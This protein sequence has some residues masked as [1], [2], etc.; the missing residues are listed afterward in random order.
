MKHYKKLFSFSELRLKGTSLLNVLSDAFQNFFRN[1]DWNQAAAIAFYGIVSL[2][3]LLIL[4]LWVGGLIFGSNP[5]LQADIISRIKNINPSFPDYLLRQISQIVHNKAILGWVGLITLLW[6]S[7]L[8]FDSIQSAFKSIFR[9]RKGR[10]FLASKGLALAMIPLWWSV[11]LTSIATAYLLRLIKNN[12]FIADLGWVPGAGIG[13]TFVQSFFWGYALPFLLMTSFVTVLYKIIPIGRVS[14]GDALAGG[15]LFSGLMEIAKHAFA[16]YID[17]F[18]RYGVIYGSLHTI[19]ILVVWVYYV[20]LILLLCAELLSSYHH[21]SLIVLEKALTQSGRGDNI[22]AHLFRKFGR[23]YRE[24]EYIFQEGDKGAEIFYILNGRALEE[25][26][27]GDKMIALSELEAGQYFGEI[28]AMLNQQRSTFVKATEDSDIAVI[29]FDT[30]KN[31]LL[32]NNEVSLVMLRSL[33]RKIQRVSEQYDTQ[34]QE[35][36]KTVVV[37]YFLREQPLTEKQ[38]AIQELVGYTGKNPADIEEALHALE[39]DHVLLKK[40]S[41]LFELDREKAFAI[42]GGCSTQSGPS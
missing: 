13:L 6:A 7:S 25:K 39:K 34:K 11:G 9:V 3:P 31:S 15:I 24:G 17:T 12:P 37:L 38:S 4:T 14:W 42:L 18:T 10:S 2:I 29:D 32:E 33:S 19:V 41:H 23:I 30:L 16:W 35:W 1:D 40:E 20:A 27:V 26:R 22:R 28:A 5:Q 21:R 8:I 36:L